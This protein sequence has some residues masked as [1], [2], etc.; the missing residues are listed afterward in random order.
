M[1]GIIYAVYIHYPLY[2]AL[3]VGY[4]MNFPQVSM[5]TNIPPTLDNI[6]HFRTCLLF[7]LLS[8]FKLK[9]VNTS[10]DFRLE[11]KIVCVLNYFLYTCEHAAMCGLGNAR[12]V[13]V[14][15]P[16]SRVCGLYVRC[17]GFWTSLCRHG[18]LPLC[19][20]EQNL[21]CILCISLCRWA[22]FS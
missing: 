16:G 22:F 9:N 17:C 8:L 3:N 6:V 11:F 21:T 18:N 1:H 15:I 2:T 13:R 4:K 19:K 14:I 12:G 20:L 7:L 10:R 5:V